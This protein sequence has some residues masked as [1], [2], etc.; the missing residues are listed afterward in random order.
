MNSDVAWVAGSNY[1]IN[2]ALFL[3]VVIGKKLILKSSFSF[4]FLEKGWQL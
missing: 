1:L 2:V 4:V 3:L